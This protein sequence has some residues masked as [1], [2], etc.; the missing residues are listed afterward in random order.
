MGALVYGTLS[1]ICYFLTGSEEVAWNISKALHGWWLIPMSMAIACYLIPK[2]TENTLWSKL[3][4]IT[5]II[6]IFFTLTPFNSYTG[7]GL[8]ADDAGK[9]LIDTG[10]DLRLWGKGY[11]EEVVENDPELMALQIWQQDEPVDLDNFY[12][13]D[14]HQILFLLYLHLML[15]KQYQMNL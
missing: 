8:G 3:L 12:Q 15:L 6:M 4:A 11:M 5:G 2:N 10:E 1:N 14:Y 9:A 7:E 13:W